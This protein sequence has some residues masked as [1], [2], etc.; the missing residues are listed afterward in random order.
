MNLFGEL[1]K[2]T[3]LFMFGTIGSKTISFFMLPVF[4]KYLSTSDYGIVDIINI[5]INLLLPIATLDISAALF[6]FLF[7]KDERKEISEL[8]YTS[9]FVLIIG[10][11]A[12]FLI[13]LPLM[14]NNIVIV[15]FRTQVYALFFLTGLRTLL[16]E[17]LRAKE[18]LSIFILS[19]WVYTF[20]FASFSIAFIVFHNLGIGGYISAQILSSCI[21]TAILIVGARKILLPRWVFS[22]AS[23]PRMLRYS[24]PLIPNMVAWW[25]VNVSDR[26][27]VTIYLGLGAA[28]I[29]AVA[30]RIAQLFQ[31]GGSIFQQAWQISGIKHGNRSGEG[32][33]STTFNLLTLFLFTII[34]IVSPILKPL[35]FLMSQEPFHDAWK[36]LVFLSLGAFFHIQSNFL[37]VAYLA[38]KKTIGNSISTLLGG[39]SNLVLNLLL[40]PRFGLIAAS[41]TTMIAYFLI[42]VYRF[43]DVRRFWEIELAGKEYIVNLL[44]VTVSMVSNF[45]KFSICFQ[46]L[47]LTL[48]C[49]MNYR[50]LTTVI[51]KSLRIIRKVK[52]RKI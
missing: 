17:L 12:L 5:S 48:F 35:V 39:V 40:I 51:L 31:I 34:L 52:Q 22:M 28:G 6:R 24:I 43:V 16:R 30:N 18:I 26:Y 15:Q 13:S 20:S 23:I 10:S 4:T 1:F 14:R 36:S 47:A 2:N 45:S 41:I 9:L 7:D 42:F 33:H 27:I 38:S 50:K 19:D 25:I 49:L 32:F 8:F 3:F 11:A 37:G 46:I 29:Y 21:S 44:L